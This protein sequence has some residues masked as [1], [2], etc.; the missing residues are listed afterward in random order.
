MLTAPPFKST[1]SKFYL[2]K[3]KTCM[4]GI[5]PEN[6]ILELSQKIVVNDKSE[7]FGKGKYKIGGIAF[8]SFAPILD[9]IN[10]VEKYGRL[11]GR[12][13]KSFKN[14]VVNNL[15]EWTSQTAINNVRKGIENKKTKIIWSS[16]KFWQEQM[17][18]IKKLKN[19]VEKNILKKSDHILCVG[20]YVKHNKFDIQLGLTGTLE[21]ID[22]NSSWSCLKREVKEEI[23]IDLTENVL[24][25]VVK[26]K[27]VYIV[28]LF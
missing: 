26:K 27:D 8:V 16:Y 11:D 14:F 5:V 23:N 20:Y 17:I 3:R 2:K 18:A 12:I 10:E 22:K 1:N 21:S 19:L 7:H 9:V 6:K 24:S 15:D 4:I 25:K 28:Q 13:P